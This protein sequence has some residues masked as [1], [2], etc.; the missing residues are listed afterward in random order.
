MKAFFATAGAAT[1]NDEQN[2]QTQK[3]S[4]WFTVCFH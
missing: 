1:H 3:N 4:R 2:Q